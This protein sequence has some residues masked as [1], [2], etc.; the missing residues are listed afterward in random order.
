MRVYFKKFNCFY[1]DDIGRSDRAI[2]AT[3]LHLSFYSDYVKCLKTLL[4]K[5]FSSIIFQDFVFFFEFTDPA[6]EAFFLIWSNDGI[7]I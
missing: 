4:A 5:E 6:D 1:S 7:E 3:N 2:T